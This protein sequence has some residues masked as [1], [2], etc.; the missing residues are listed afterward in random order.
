MVEPLANVQVFVSAP[1]PGSTSANPIEISK[2]FKAFKLVT[3]PRERPRRRPP[4]LRST[5]L[6]LETLGCKLQRERMLLVK[7]PQKTRA[8]SCVQ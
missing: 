2:T 5:K 6:E 8:L 4:A 1:F 7:F 3:R